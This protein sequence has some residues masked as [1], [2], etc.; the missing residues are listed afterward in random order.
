MKEIWLMQ[1]RFEQRA[2][3]R[4]FRLLEQ[5]RF[6]AGF[7]FL[8]LRCASGEVDDE[9]GLWWDEFQDASAERQAEML[10]PE[11]ASE[12]KRRRRKPRKKSE[13]TAGEPAAAAD[14]PIV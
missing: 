7:D 11:G 8:L 5:P 14:E 3:Q 13:A 6:R 12:K 1:Q 9:L 10:Q 4:P 2:G